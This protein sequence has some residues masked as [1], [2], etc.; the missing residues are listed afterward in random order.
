MLKSSL[1][2]YSDAYI[3]VK[4]TINVVKAGADN[5]ARATVRNDAQTIFKNCVSFTN[6][7]SKIN[8]KQV[9][10]AKDLDAV[11]HQCIY[12]LIE[13]SDNY[14][15]TSRSL[16]Q[17]CRDEPKNPIA[18]SELLKFKSRFLNNTNNAKLICH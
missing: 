14:L 10:N 13:Y 5:V 6:C 18:D 1:C 17:F 11:I 2:D 9:D 16:Y 12:N 4:G 7:I 3:L 15:K 8:N